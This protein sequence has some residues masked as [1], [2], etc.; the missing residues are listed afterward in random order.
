MKY[1]GSDIKLAREK[2]DWDVLQL[3]SLPVSVF[4]E[5]K[6]GDNPRE[7]CLVFDQT[8]PIITKKKN[9][10]STHMAASK[11][12]KEFLN[13]KFTVDTVTEF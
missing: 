5:A 7:L 10:F 2:N 11:P 8:R 6:K 1:A 9:A 12:S 4:I 13:S 3:L